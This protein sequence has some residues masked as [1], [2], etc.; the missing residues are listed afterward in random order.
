MAQSAACKSS[1]LIPR[2][3]PCSQP[4]IPLA[5]PNTRASPSDPMQSLS[6]YVLQASNL[7]A[8]R[9]RVACSRK[10]NGW[11]YSKQRYRVWLDHKLLA[12]AEKLTLRNSPAKLLIDFDFIPQSLKKETTKNASFS[13]YLFSYER[14]NI[15]GSIT[16]VCRSHI[17]S[18]ILST[19]VVSIF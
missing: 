12:A 13:A 6:H 8:G 2:P 10:W 19:S 14:Q 4:Y 5:D 3:L 1:R 16:S 9:R 15:T 17:L 11:W 7:F 18:H